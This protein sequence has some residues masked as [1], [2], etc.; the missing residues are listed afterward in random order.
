MNNGITQRGYDALFFFFTF[1]NFQLIWVS[2]LFCLRS[3]CH[4]K[5]LCLRKI[6]E[7]VAAEHCNFLFYPLMSVAHAHCC[8]GVLYGIEDFFSFAPCLLYYL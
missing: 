8:F 3:L 6:E 5:L 2:V 7:E 4:F 1:F